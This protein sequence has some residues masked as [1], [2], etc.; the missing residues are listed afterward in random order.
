MSINIL[1]YVLGVTSALCI[2]KSG[3]FTSG[4]TSLDTE[5]NAPPPIDCE[6]SSWGKWSEC[7]PC[8]KL[9]YRS[10]SI[11]KFGQYGGRPCRHSLGDSQS[12]KPDK[13]CEERSV[14][15]GNDF[16]CESGRCIKTRLLC[17]GDND[18]GDHSDELC[19]DGQDP[20]SPCRN[21][22]IE[23]SELGRTAGDGLNILGM[24][25]LRNPFDNEYFNGICDRVRDGNT[26]TYYRKPWN[27]AA[28]VYQTRSD[29]SFTTETFEDAKDVIHRISEEKTSEFEA[30]LS[31]K[32]TPTEIN[33][34]SVNITGKLG[35]NT[36]RNESLSNLKKYEEN[37]T[38]TF[39]KVS[40]SLQLA[41]FQMRTR[42]PMLSISFLEDLRSLPTS[43]EKAD[44][45]SFLEMYGTH[46]T[47]SGKLGG[48]FELVY[49]LDSSVMKNQAITTEDVKD[50]LGF[51]LDANV[52]SQGV[53]LKAEIKN[54]KCT[55]N[56]QYDE[57]NPIK[58]SVIT[59]VISFVE[60][61]TVQAAIL[62]D[63]KQKKQDVD[64]EDFVNW[65]SSIVDAPVVIKQK[66][67][68]IYNLIPPEMFNAYT[69]TRNLERAI[70][71]YLDEHSVCK[72][73]PCQ[74][75]G[76]VMVIDGICLCKCPIRYTGVACQT[77]K[78]ELYER[79]SAVHGN[80][81]CWS[82]VSSC[83]NGEIKLSRTCDNPAPQNG[84]RPCAGDNTRT[85]PC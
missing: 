38:K 78:S 74:N 62:L 66:P 29:K 77:P 40:G 50:C 61:G 65:A 41:T 56:N 52:A 58:K 80:W 57:N 67:A 79:E 44:Y 21:M 45:F 4:D 20:K 36:S 33:N 34:D 2:L 19:E 26:K 63:E 18:C 73:Q 72:C 81:G 10:R 48:K 32:V 70:E 24:D 42:S 59:D 16:E 68:P 84:G 27:V 13:I 43:Y 76:T 64:V 28:L 54:P 37:K 14:D 31:L 17:N 69:K 7:D 60:G 1:H 75:G 49:V 83:T 25:T 51:N 5:V 12:C 8:T 15:C 71:D 11:V 85:L 46:Y 6:L 3:V 22:D 30:S 9:R 53:D 47:V 35:I 39:F 23:L 55:Q 82:P